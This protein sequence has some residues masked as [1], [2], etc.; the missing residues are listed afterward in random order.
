MQEKVL[1]AKSSLKQFWQSMPTVKERSKIKKCVSKG[2]F[3]L[4]RKTFNKNL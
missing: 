3:V 4:G 2:F 1:T